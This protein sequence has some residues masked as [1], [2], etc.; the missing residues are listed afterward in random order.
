MLRLSL[1]TRECLHLLPFRR[2]K[3]PLA[4]KPRSLHACKRNHDHRAAIAALAVAALHGA[5]AAL[6]GAVAAS[7]AA[8][9]P[10]AALALA[11]ATVAQPAAAVAIAATT[12]AVA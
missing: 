11:A 7:D 10:A 4:G 8:A 12:I 6:H 2:N 9:Q 1:R 5:V 3:Q